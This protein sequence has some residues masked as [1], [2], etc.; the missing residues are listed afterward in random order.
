MDEQGFE[1]RQGLEIFLLTT[2]YKPDFWGPPSFLSNGYQG[3]CPRVKRSRR[4]AE[5]LPPSSAEV[6]N[7]WSFTST[8]QHV[9]AM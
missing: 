6:K 4:E 1:T 8:P 5:H 9:F 3:V 2:A 7:A